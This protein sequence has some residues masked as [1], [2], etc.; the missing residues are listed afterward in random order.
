MA[1][2]TDAS[3]GIGYV[4]AKSFIKSVCH[5]VIT[6]TNTEKLKSCVEKFGDNAK[7]IQL[8]LNDLLDLDEKVREAVEC[9]GKN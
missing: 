7:E 9:Y 8:N 4:I 6:G 5:V 1:L 2:M 3:G